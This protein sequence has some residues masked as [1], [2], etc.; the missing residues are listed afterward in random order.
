M[1]HL[2]KTDWLSIKNLTRAINLE[3]KDHELA[4]DKGP[5]GGMD[6]RTRGRFIYLEWIF[7]SQRDRS[8]L[9]VDGQITRCET[10][11]ITSTKIIMRAR[12]YGCLIFGT[13]VFAD[14]EEKEEIREGIHC[15]T[16]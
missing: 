14:K 15:R 4:F 7:A 6:R 9:L 11:I 16:D 8:V 10:D 2:K 5:S 12:G 13:L 1:T 3:K